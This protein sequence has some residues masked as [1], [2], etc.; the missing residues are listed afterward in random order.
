MNVSLYQL[1]G[2]AEERFLAECDLVRTA[3]KTK[4]RNVLVMLG[5]AAACL[6]LCFAAYLFVN[7]LPIYV[8]DDVAYALYFDTENI[9]S[10]ELYYNVD[11]H[12]IEGEE[13]LLPESDR[14][15]VALSSDII[16]LFNSNKFDY[17]VYDYKA[18]DKYAYDMVIVIDGKPKLLINSKNGIGFTNIQVNDK[19]RT[20]QFQLTAEEQQAISDL[21]E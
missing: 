19:I 17:L 9:Q 14:Y 20:F 16:E 18:W 6:A 15:V 1:A 5:T 7:S 10:A 4:R 12:V 11:G 2:Y 8:I 13:I 3:E 21:I